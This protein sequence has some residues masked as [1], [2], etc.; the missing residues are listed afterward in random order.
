MNR[1]KPVTRLVLLP[2]WFLQ[3]LTGAS[4]FIDNPLIGSQRLNRWGLHRARVRLAARL[5]AWRRRRLAAKVRP[6]W[7]EAFD[8]DGFVVIR[9]VAPADQFAALRRAILEYRGPAREMR[10]G[11]AI[12]RRLSVDP[13]MLA[14]V[15]GLR[16]LL[17]RA[18]LVA[19]FNYVAG[20]R[21]TPLHYVQTIVAGAGG[22]EAD[23][24]ETLHAD[25]FHASL[26]AWLFLNPVAEDA[27]P[28]QFV[29]GSHRATAARL[30][31]EYRRSLRDPAI[32][33]RLTGRGSPRV[34]EFDLAELG[35][36]SPCACAVPA[37]TL[38]V[39]DTFGI[40][41]RGKSA[42]PVERV[43]LWS[44]ARRNPFI[45]WLGGDLLSLPG[46]AERRVGWLWAMRDLLEPRLGQ[47]WRKAGLRTALGSDRPNESHINE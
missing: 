9:D 33:D 18:D 21:M 10:Q 34:E 6:D 8:R 11:D 39:A 28:F 43:E 3:L 35:L 4:S 47:P 16:D 14:A 25:T 12:T 19:L 27:A 30:D 42:T 26:K 15:P 29:A 45:P 2:V 13:A 44:Y 36:P 22:N 31:W 41:A 1:F 7:R 37:N 32:L 5:C 38:V 24:Q 17:A 23:P 46:L 40:H 20:F